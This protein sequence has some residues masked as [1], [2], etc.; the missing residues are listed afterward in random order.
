MH[1]GQGFKSQEEVAK[2]TFE[3]GGFLL[4]RRVTVIKHCL[5]TDGLTYVRDILFL[6]FCT[7]Y[8]QLA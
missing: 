5:F 3:E 6:L 1:L 7:T 8:N 2:T 4:T